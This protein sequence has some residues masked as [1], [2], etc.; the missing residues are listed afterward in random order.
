MIEESIIGDINQEN[1]NE[2]NI[3]TKELLNNLLKKLLENKI[4]KLEKKHIEESNTLKGISKIS[5]NIIISLDYYSHKV[6]KELYK[7]R[8]KNDENNDNKKKI[9]ENNKEEKSSILNNIESLIESKEN[10]LD[11][12]NI[13]NIS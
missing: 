6:R 9:I 4:S 3:K 10:N 7:I 2:N 5:Q 8:H 12:N 11:N 13:N 1:E